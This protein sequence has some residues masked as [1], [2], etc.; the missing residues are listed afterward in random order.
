MEDGQTQY[1]EYTVVAGDCLWTIAERFLGAGWRWTELVELNRDVVIGESLIYPGQKLLIPI[2]EK[3]APAAAEPMGEY[4]EYTV[5]AGDCLW[6][7][8]DRFLGAGWKWRELYVLNQDIIPSD[9][10]IYP[11][12][13]L[14]VPRR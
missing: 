8:S 4:E 14:R 6:A 3:T 1:L 2:E 13:K 10:F 7:I 5:A 9:G 12:Q 11:G